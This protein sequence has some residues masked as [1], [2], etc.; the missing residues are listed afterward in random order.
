MSRRTTRPETADADP[1]VVA[2]RKALALARDSAVVALSEAALNIGDNDEFFNHLETVQEA[3]RDEHRR[4]GATGTYDWQELPERLQDDA[5][6][7]ATHCRAAGYLYGLAVGLTLS[8]G[9]VR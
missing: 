1:Q 5:L 9:G 3:L 8:R 6:S 4:Q 7:L 2:F